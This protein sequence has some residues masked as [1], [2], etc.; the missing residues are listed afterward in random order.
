MNASHTADRTLPFARALILVFAPFAGGYF[1]SYLFRSVNAIVAPNLISELGIDAEELGL[2]AAAYFLS[3][4]ICQVP[5]GVLL[6]RYGSRRVQGTLYMLAAVGALLFAVAENV[7]TL[8]VARALIG[9]G[10]SGGLM[11]A[12]KSIV[13][14]FPEDKIPIV[15]GWYF[16][17]GSIGALSSTVPV[18]FGISLIGW[19]GVFVVLAAGT[20]IAALLILMI[21]P[22][23]KEGIDRSSWANNIRGL[24]WIYRD[25]YFWR[26]APLMF[27]SASANMAVQGLWA[28]PWLSD[29]NGLERSVV[30]NHLFV[31]AVGMIFGTFVSGFF[32]N[33]LRRLGLSMA[34]VSVVGTIIYTLCSLA[35]VMD[36]IANTYVI[37][38]M[39]GFSGIFAAIVF[40]AFAF[41]F[42]STHT[43]R[44]NT[45]CNVFVF[46][47]AFSYQ[48]G[49]GYIIALWPQSANGSYP[50]VAYYVAF[51][52]VVGTQIG[53]IVWFFVL[54]ALSKRARG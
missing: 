37:W 23:K 41:H 20:L 4:A 50:A 53:A 19:R 2:I 45:A 35:L 26:L 22:D 40:A 36:L 25:P 8:F 38:A 12:L 13:Q 29:V 5:L 21:V 7:S 34:Q 10:V 43:G 46:S 27:T 15:N 42:P 6:D 9:I 17:S 51:W 52:I 16:T 44:A 31:L 1:F 32:A 54:G 33:G 18:E 3:F 48:Y 28:G 24:V 39:I 14:W 47:M 49:I 30:A 11:A